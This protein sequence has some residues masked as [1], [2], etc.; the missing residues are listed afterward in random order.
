M[1]VYVISLENSKRRDDLKQ[2]LEIGGITDYEIVDAQEPHISN[3]DF[4]KSMTNGKIWTH[5]P[6]LKN[7]EKNQARMACYI[8]HVDRVL[9]EAKLANEK[10]IL[11]LED[12]IVFKSCNILDICDTLPS[13][14]LIGFLDTTKLEYVNGAEQGLCCDWEKID[15][16]KL[17][18]WCAGCYLVRDT[19]KVLDLILNSTPKV[20]DKLL[21]DPIQ[22]H[23]TCYVH[24]PSVAKQDRNKFKSNIC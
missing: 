17:R 24:L 9:M 10:E 4:I 16:S 18:V 8:S 23:H 14:A 19:S 5:D 7:E 2:R 12:D 11:I 20:Y 22:K 3:C 21:I 13:D 6:R 15:N 1:K